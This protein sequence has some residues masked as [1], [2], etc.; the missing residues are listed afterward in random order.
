MCNNYRPIF[1]GSLYCEICLDI[2]CFIIQNLHQWMWVSLL[3]RNLAEEI[4]KRILNLQNIECLLTKK[5]YGAEILY[6]GSWINCG[7]E[8]DKSNKKKYEEKKAH[9]EDRTQIS[10]GLTSK[11]KFLSQVSH[12]QGH[13]NLWCRF[14]LMQYSSYF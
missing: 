12:K 6:G 1:H 3:M 10:S 8:F 13:P 5:C 4:L 9:A 2:L 14:W 11:F 7:C